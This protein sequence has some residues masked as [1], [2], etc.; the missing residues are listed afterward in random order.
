M[1]PLFSSERELNKRKQKMSYLIFTGFVLLAFGPLVASMIHFSWQEKRNKAAAPTHS[2]QAQSS[3]RTGSG[4][5]T[6]TPLLVASGI[7][8]LP[9]NSSSSNVESASTDSSCGGGDGGGGGD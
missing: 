7:A 1:P 4:D 3:N 5:D 9:S 8:C 2:A 6:M